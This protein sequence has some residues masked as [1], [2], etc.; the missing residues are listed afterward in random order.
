MCLGVSLAQSADL[1]I[2]I[3]FSLIKGLQATVHATK[4]RPKFRRAHTHAKFSP[5]TIYKLPS[6]L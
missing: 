5:T 3:H 4:T 2:V 6:R 1:S